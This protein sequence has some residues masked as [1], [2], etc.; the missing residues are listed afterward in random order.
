MRLRLEPWSPAY[1]TAAIDMAG[2]EDG[3]AQDLN[4]QAELER[5]QPVQTTQGGL[6]AR[7]LFFID[8]TRRTEAKLVG[9]W[10]E[11]SVVRH[12]PGLLGAYGVGVAEVDASRTPSACRVLRAAVF[13]SI[14]VGG[15]ITPEP[16]RIRGQGS[17]LGDLHYLGESI[18][19][20]TD[21]DGALERRLHNLMREAEHRIATETVRPGELLVVDGPLG[22]QPLKN[23]VGYVKTLHNLMVPPFEQ[24]ILFAL[25]RGQ[26]TPVFLI[27]GRLDRYSWFL[28][29]SDGVGWHQ[30]L[31]GVVRLEVHASN[32]FDFARAVA[33]W[34]CLELP[35]FAAKGFRDPRAPQQ[36]MPVAFLEAELGRR[37]G[38]GSIVRRRIQL[39]LRDLY[40][41]EDQDDLGL[42]PPAS[43]L[44]EAVS[45]LN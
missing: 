5:W 38:D 12:A 31:S 39:H 36:L 44:R 20:D 26:R 6:A 41:L 10:N 19:D 1:D 7:R 40:A 27:G 16:L 17:R 37:M 2:V 32:G 25:Q 33:D 11:G 22:F 42:E 8:G 29:L 34:S 45:E 28:R 43:E 9:E 4:L 23:A 14:I 24:R 13:R 30:G 18:A 21:R 15:G 35:R 3:K